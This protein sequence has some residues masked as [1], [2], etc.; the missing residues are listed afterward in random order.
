MFSH[1]RRIRQVKRCLNETCLRIFT[2]ALVISRLDY[3]YSVLSALPSSTLQPLSS[4]LHTAARLIKGLGPR[5]HI[6]S[7]LKQLHWL[8]IRARIAFKISLLMFHIH[9]G[10]SPSYMASMVTPCSASKSR[11]LRS[12]SRSDFATLRTYRKLGS[13]AFSASGPKEWN[14]LPISIRQC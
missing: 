12:S 2:Q 1:L 6:T 14:S 13:R 5:D 7:T 8:P 3:C 9:Y 4:V 11:G 10:T